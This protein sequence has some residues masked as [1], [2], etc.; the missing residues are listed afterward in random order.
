M[1][2]ESGTTN[3]L[4]DETS[5]YLLQHAGNP[6]DW[7]PWGTEAFEEARRS[8]RPV[9][10]SVGYAA[11]HWCHVM[12]HE[13]FEDESVAAVM[14]RLF[15]NIKVD[16]EERPDVDQIY[17]NALHA[18]GEQGGWPLTMF[19]TPAGEPFWGG[20]YF[21]KTTRYGRPGFTQVLESISRIFHEE[22]E[23]VTANGTAL[24]N[25]LQQLSAP[26][27]PGPEPTP[28]LLEAA[29]SRLVSLL[30]PVHGGLR[31][32]PKFPQPTLLN[33]LL[34]Q[35]LRT[36][37]EP[38]LAS[39]VFALERMSQGGIY[40]HVGGGFARYS[41]DDRWLVPH[42]EKMLYDNG[43]LLALLAHAEALSGAWPFRSRIEETI[44]WLGREMKVDGGGFAASLDA[45]T[46]GHEGLTY[47]WTPDEIAEVLG[48]E[49]ANLVFD[50]YDVSRTGNFEGRNILNRTLAPQR[51]GLTESRLSD[52]L[53]RLLA[54][55]NRRPQPGRD[56]KVLADWNALV[57]R[58]LC[59]AGVALARPDWIARA[60]TAYRF[61]M[62]VMADV[63]G[64]LAHATRAGRFTRPGL[65]TDHAGMA[66]AAIALHQ[67]TFRPEFIDEAE[68][69]LAILDRHYAATDGLFHL[70]ADD[71]ADLIVRPK[72]IH[73]EAT[74][75]ANGLAARA[76]LDLYLLTGRQRHLDRADA[77]FRA[78]GAEIARNI[79]GA[80]STLEAF[81]RRLDMAS[82]V[83]VGPPGEERDLLVAAARR[84]QPTAVLFVSESTDGLGPVHPAS[85]KAAVDGVP[86]AYVCKGATCS[87]PVTDPRALRGL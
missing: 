20:T 14:N 28:D 84:L 74:P 59:A 40:D 9:L 46:E 15:V 47:V 42:F 56:D 25:H 82:V 52:A 37:S 54:A 69:L 17:M 38:M 55:R 19:L 60:E 13:S 71:V 3:R 57:I 33:L 27:S 2:T 4:A 23:K 36:R 22:P 87:L 18:L 85:G 1:T 8:N 7:Y 81:A 12:A 79:V 5:P 49:D 64:R 75:N 72:S 45:D 26:S 63:D 73:D 51:D 39:V 50:A 83:V 68:A 76:S 77:I 11:C 62:D 31:G 34:T 66:A 78:A 58:G 61:V 24:S 80:A 29:C 10:L 43:Q 35:G 6:V 65:A 41:V 48:E 53:G 67:A 32:A 86:A 16:R 44:A 21:P 70:S 30:D